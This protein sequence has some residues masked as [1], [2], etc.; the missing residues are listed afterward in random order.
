MRSW[1]KVQDAQSCEQLN[2]GIFVSSHVKTVFLQS[3]CWLSY[4]KKVSCCFR[5]K[6]IKGWLGGDQTEKIEGWSTKVYEASGKMMAVTHL[7]SDW[8][9]PVGASFKD[10]LEMEVSD[11][12]VVEVPVNLSNIGKTPDADVRPISKT[13]SSSSHVNMVAVNYHLCFVPLAI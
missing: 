12:V 13:M 7:K 5:F 4:A 11:D 9:I 6:P 3:H 10:Y 8:R 2:L 1:R